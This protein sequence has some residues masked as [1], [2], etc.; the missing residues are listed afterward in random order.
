MRIQLLTF[1]GCPHAHG[2]RQALEEAIVRA[3]LRVRIE[4]V[5]TTSPLTP[6][7]LRL[8]S[9]P[10]ILVDG[11]D[12][13]GEIAPLGGGCRLYRHDDGELRGAPQAHL[14]DT[15]LRRAI[16]ATAG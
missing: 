13:G 15:A 3:G 4:E 11:R 9:S 10:T 6:A 1:P 14:L 12:V 7:G 5:D 2:A 16:P 8:W